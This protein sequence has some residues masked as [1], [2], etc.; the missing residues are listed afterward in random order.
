MINLLKMEDTALKIGK[1]GDD[2][3]HKNPLLLNESI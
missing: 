1:S 2:I 3:K